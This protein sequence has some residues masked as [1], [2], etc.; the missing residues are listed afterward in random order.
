MR[1]EQEEERNWG[2]EGGKERKEEEEEEEEEEAEEMTVLH[3][4]ATSSPFAE[5]QCLSSRSVRGPPAAFRSS[6][7]S[8]LSQK[9]LSGLTLALE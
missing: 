5:S 9:W 1:S 4:L 7:A 6:E 2:R 8:H 3:L